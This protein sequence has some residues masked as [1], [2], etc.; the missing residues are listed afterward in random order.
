MSSVVH[1]VET[2]L[3]HISDIAWL[4][5]LYALLCHTAKM[6]VRSRAWRNVLV[7]A[8]PKSTVSWRSI[9]GAYAAGAGVNAVVPVRGGD[10]LNLYLVRRRIVGSSYPTLASSLLVPAVVD[11]AL[12]SLLLAWALGTHVL[13]GV[14]L[15]RRLPA[16]DWS[17]LFRHPRLALA[18]FVAAVVVSFLAG[19]LA[20]GRIAEFRERV[21]QGLTVLRSPHR[22]VAGVVTWQL[23]DWGLRIATIYFFL[24]AFHIPATL[25]NA[26][27]V[28]V[29]QSLATIL[30]LTP[31]GIGTKQALLVYVLRGQESR[32]AL[33][34]FSVGMELVLTV[35]NVALGGAALAVMLRTLRWRRRLAADRELRLDSEPPPADSG[36][37]PLAGRGHGDALG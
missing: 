2:F 4:P 6:L 18:V 23:L 5:V 8:Y 19:V 31:S 28:Q 10:L 32:T 35:W 20:A 3:A 7:A 22:Y 27:R 36:G 24:R 34:S 17:W 25:D 11:L 21:G 26:L 1:A 14:R 9:F 12:S 29:T 13:P 33:L 37:D 16:I 30:P 15:V